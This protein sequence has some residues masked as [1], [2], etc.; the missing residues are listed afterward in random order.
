[1]PTWVLSVRKGRLIVLL[2]RDGRSGGV[3]P[4]RVEVTLADLRRDRD[5]DGLTDRL[6]R[7]IGTDPDRSDT[8]GDGMD[9]AW[10]QSFFAPW[11]VPLPQLN[12]ILWLIRS[13]LERFG[14]PF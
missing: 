10:E 12:A 4:R 9:D 3:S 11:T 14:A 1:M 5:H 7:A 6:E 13:C 2:Q 8:D